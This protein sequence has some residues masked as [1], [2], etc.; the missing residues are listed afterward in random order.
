[1]GDTGSILLPRTTAEM[2]SAAAIAFTFNRPSPEIPEIPDIPN[3]DERAEIVT[4]RE[5]T[6]ITTSTLTKR[7][8]QRGVTQKTY[9]SKRDGKY[10]WEI[11]TTDDEYRHAEV[12]K[13]SMLVLAE[14][15]LHV[16]DDEYQLGDYEFWRSVFAGPVRNLDVYVDGVP[17]TLR[18]YRDAYSLPITGAHVKD[19]RDVVAR[20]YEDA[21]AE[22]DCA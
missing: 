5:T 13:A 8:V 10:E 15:E 2:L 20:A 18:V 17:K 11:Y 21:L 9:G 3:D 1:M 6:I 22:R 12:S 4:M 16:D 14:F 7:D 19:V